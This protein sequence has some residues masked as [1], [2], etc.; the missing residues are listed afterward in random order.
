MYTITSRDPEDLARAA[1]NVGTPTN[2]DPLAMLTV[3][4]QT[5]PFPGGDVCFQ[6][7]RTWLVQSGMKSLVWYLKHLDARADRAK[8]TEVFGRGHPRWPVNNLEFR[9]EHSAVPAIR[10]GFIVHFFAV[11]PEPR[12]VAVARPVA[13]VRVAQPAAVVRRVPALPNWAGDRWVGHW[14]VSVGGGLAYGSNNNIGD[15]PAVMPQ[16]GRVSIDG[17]FAMFKKRQADGTYERGCV[18]E[19]DPAGIPERR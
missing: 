11:P 17:Q 7:V 10:R 19:I 14:A 5:R 4:R 2:P 13:G 15:P 12:Q 18:E 8:L 16:F 9:P 3:T 1:E 6:A